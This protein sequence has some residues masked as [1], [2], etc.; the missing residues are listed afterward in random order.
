MRSTQLIL[1]AVL[2]GVIPLVKL[3]KWVQGVQKERN[4][5]IIWNQITPWPKAFHDKIF[6]FLVHL[7]VPFS[8]T[9]R[10]QVHALSQGKCVTRVKVNQVEWPT[11]LFCLIFWSGIRSQKNCLKDLL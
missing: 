7:A 3:V 2:L 6:N 8:K 4:P 1:P 5:L 10:V 9:G 11:L